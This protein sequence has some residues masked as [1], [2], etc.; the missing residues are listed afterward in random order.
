MVFHHVQINFYFRHLH[1]KRNFTFL[2]FLVFFHY[3]E[4][5]HLDGF[6]V[7]DCDAV[8][9]IISGHHYTSTPEDTVAVA[10]HAGTD[11]DCGGFY[12]QH[13]QAA[14]DNKTIVEA[15]IDQ[16][17]VR[18]F[19]VLVRLGYFDPPEQ[20]PYRKLSKADVD[21]P[22]SR[23]LTLEA[24]QQSIVLLKNLNKALPLNINQLQNKK[25]AL[26]GPSANA[27]GL[28]QGNYFGRAPYLIDPVTAFQNVT[29]G[30]SI[31]VSFA[32]GCNINDQDQSGFA[33]AISLAQ[34]SDV[35]IFVGGIDE[36]EESEGHDRTVIELPQIQLA[37][38]QQLEKVVRSPLHVV[39]MSGGGVD[40]TYVRD[41]NECGSLIW[42]G[43][44]GQSG[45]LALA[46]VMLGQYNPGGRLPITYY[47]ASYVANLSMFDMQM[48]PSPTNPGRTY[49]FYTGQPVFEFGYGLSYTTFNYTWYNESSSSVI[50]I[51]NIMKNKD[52]GSKLAM[53]SYRV[54]VTNTGSVLGD[55]V[56]LAYVTPPTKSLH[57]PSPPMKKLFGF[58]R[59]RLDV[60]QTTQ[61]FFPLNPDALFTVGS[62]GSKWLEPGAYRIL[63][64]KQHMHTVYLRG[65]PTRWI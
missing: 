19:N 43:Y 42:M 45:G 13:T 54:N 60:G 9:T 53:E 4:S 15:D 21:T 63:I 14:L 20:Q 33:E 48:R 61:V 30:H 59:V 41:S 35:V 44:A 58:E 12:Q 6:V 7:S 39:I 27:G 38:I 55:D 51:R 28:M 24:A 46:N 18:T 62:D 8:D 36:H 3:R 37:L 49:K 32:H 50:S 23:Q 22:E 34:G 40:L 52:L 17:L 25:I 5:Y 64:G 31:N 47:P 57:D 29:Q 11:L 26:I 16:A 65:T 10:L 56:V 1:G 2:K